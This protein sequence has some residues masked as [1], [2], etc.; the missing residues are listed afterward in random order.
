MT[1]KLWADPSA[2][3]STYELDH[4]GGQVEEL[5]AQI[6]ATEAEIAVTAD[7]AASRNR[8]VAELSFSIDVR[9]RER[10]TPQLQAFADATAS[11]AR[12]DA[13][14]RELE[15]TLTQWDR[16]DDLEAHAQTLE[17]RLKAHKDELDSAQ[18]LLES[19]RTEVFD[20][21][22]AEFAETVAAIRI[23]GVSAAT[24]NRESY[25]PMLNGKSFQSFSPVGGVRTATQVAYW[26]TVITVALRRRDTYY[27]AFLLMDS[28]RTSLND[29]DDLSSALYRRLVTMA[30]AAEGRV[31]VII[32]DNE[33]PAD[34]RRDYAQLD[35]DYDHPTI[36][37]IH[38]PGRESVTPLNG[39]GAKT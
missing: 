24:I 33:L 39:S 31:Q 15:K 20:E 25:L 27:P 6:D 32:G 10:I 38:H 28:P 2:T 22:D 23:P 8:L 29:S 37:T 30:D 36:N 18:K 26:I 12:A 9:T 34:Y 35:F 5:S 3:E 7:A 16:A 4:L 17:T 21:L 19:R 1:T 13:L 14:S 11:L